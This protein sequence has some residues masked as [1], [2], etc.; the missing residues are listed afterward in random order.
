MIAA[1]LPMITARDGAIAFNEDGANSGIR[2]R[3][4]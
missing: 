3:F 4:S 2:A 1:R